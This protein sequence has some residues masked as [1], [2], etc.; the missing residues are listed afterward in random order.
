MSRL[1]VALLLVYSAS[2]GGRAGKK[3]KRWSRILPARA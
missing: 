3:R 2:P 1:R